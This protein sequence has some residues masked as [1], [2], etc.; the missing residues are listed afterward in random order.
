MAGPLSQNDEVLY[1]QAFAAV[2][3]KQFDQAIALS[4][5]AKDPLLGKVALWAAYTTPGS[6]KS[7]AEITDFIK[8]NP[9]WP[10]QSVLKRRAEEA[11]SLATPSYAIIAWFDQTAPLTVNGVIAYGK[12]LIDNNLLAKA[13]PMIEESWVNGSF[14]A[15][16]E[17]N[18]LAQFDGLIT[19]ADHWVRLDRLLWDRQDVAAG[20]QLLR[21]DSSKRA[22]AEARMALVN[23]AP[24]AQKLAAALPASAKND[25]GL[26]YEQLRLLRIKEENDK[27]I[28]LLSHPAANKVRPDMWWTERAILTRRLLQQGQPAKAYAIA[29]A[30]GQT[31]GV[32]FAD[33]EW[34]SGWIALR[35]LH[36]NQEALAHFTRM[37]ASVNSPQSQSRASY[38]AGR[39]AEALGRKDEAARWYR[40]AAPYV[41][42]FYGQLAAARVNEQH[43][44]PLPSDPLPSASE[45][46]AFERHELV[47]ASRM[48]AQ[49]DQSD[50]IRPFML[51]MNEIAQ[52]PG[53][54]ALA[55]NLATQL[56]R[57]DFAVMIAKRS[58]RDG[59]PLIASG[60]PIPGFAIGRQ[61]EKAL[62]LG[63]IRQESAFHAGAVSQ[64]GARGLMQLMPATA[65]HMAKEAGIGPVGTSQMNAA[66]INDPALNIQLG[67]TYLDKQIASFDGSYIMAIAAYNAGPGRVRRW[68][69][70][71]GDP[72]SGA[73]DPVDWVESIPYAE[74]RNYTIRVLEGTQVYRRRLGNTGLALSLDADLQRVGLR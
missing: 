33:A 28:Q 29:H 61:P 3:Q 13:R 43:L 74:T 35:F 34:L 11:I 44:W 39:A 1:R 50:Y 70:E 27:A 23:G 4:A 63:L 41:T 52:K 68:I 22:L 71:F 20:R 51:C 7:F 42:T 40:K 64:A 54:R 25:P 57:S 10:Q 47:R 59:V 32:G 69:E 19:P 6:G 18:F 58:E 14:G 9:D 72:R 45:I 2:Q 55:A 66:L 49:I 37:S 16:Q 24:N 73:V 67:S 30:H 8:A 60:Y 53:E 31:D 12:A 15:T 5:R 48:L 46:Q 36:K 21:I 65:Q 17:K 62:V 38:W 26:I 56:G